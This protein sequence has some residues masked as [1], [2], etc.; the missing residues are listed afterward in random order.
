MK[1]LY[2]ALGVSKTATTDE[3]KKA[4]RDAAFKYHPDRNPNNKQ[5]EDKFKQISAAYAVLG[6]EKKRSDYDRY[7]SADTYAQAQRPHNAQ[8]PF[9][10]DFW[11]WYSQTTQQNTQYNQRRQYSYYSTNTQRSRQPKTKSQ[12]FADLIRYGI[13]VCAGLFFFRYSWILIPIGPILCIAA[14]INGASG[15]IR[16]IQHIVSRK[17][18]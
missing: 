18:K 5:A 6:D 1:D 16:S 14:I 11:G 17:T 9:G 3:I 2:E 4:Y 13:T 10:D 7:G 8:D 15:A 12:A